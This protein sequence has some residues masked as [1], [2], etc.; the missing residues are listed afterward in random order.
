[1]FFIIL[2]YFKS[3]SLK[4]YGSK[5]SSTA[6]R[7]SP[8]NDLTGH[9]ADLLTRRKGPPGFFLRLPPRR[10]FLSCDARK[11]AAARGDAQT[12]RIGNPCAPLSGSGAFSCHFPGGVPQAAKE[13]PPAA[14][15]TGIASFKLQR[16]CLAQKRKSLLKFCYNKESSF[17]MI[18][19]SSLGFFIDGVFIPFSADRG[20]HLL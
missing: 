10:I 14:G 13:T 7:R 3:H 5:T 18:G 4:Q 16:H 6:N 1:V 12:N 9:P 19:G 2:C 8:A 17:V 11:P 20:A 15:L